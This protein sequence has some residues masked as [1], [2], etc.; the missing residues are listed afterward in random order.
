MKEEESLLQSTLLLG[1][2]LGILLLGKA[3]LLS[4]EARPATPAHFSK[5]PRWNGEEVNSAYSMQLLYHSLLPN[6]PAQDP[7]GSQT[8]EPPFTRTAA[9]AWAVPVCGLLLYKEPAEKAAPPKACERAR[10]PQAR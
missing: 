5:P 7:A 9:L 10:K 2:F 1:L 8:Q 4:E 6:R 3:T